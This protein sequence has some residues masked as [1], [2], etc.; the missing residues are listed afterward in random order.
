MINCCETWL[1]LGSYWNYSQVILSRTFK[2]TKIVFIIERLHNKRTQ[3]IQTLCK[4]LKW[5]HR[6]CSY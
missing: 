4:L 1:L 5:D 2:G 3:L 6:A